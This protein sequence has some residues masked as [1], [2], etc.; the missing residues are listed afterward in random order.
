M[1][2]ALFVAIALC[3]VIFFVFRKKKPVEMIDPQKLS[4]TQLD[5]TETF[6]DN[7]RLKPEEWVDTVPLN[8]KLPNPEAAGL[9]SVNS[10]PDIIHAVAEE[11]S[12]LREQFTQ[13][14]DGVYCP[15]C[16]IA[17]IDLNK[18]HS[19]CPKCSRKLLKFGWD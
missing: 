18:L 14:N 2:T 3:V 5:I 11:M 1:K 12:K 19:P 9:P 16:H 10:S 15:V 6:G 7:L 8:A 17:N 4:Y 13:L